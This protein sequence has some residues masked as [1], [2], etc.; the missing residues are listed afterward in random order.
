VSTT[1]WRRGSLRAV[2]DFARPSVNRP[3]VYA[4]LKK[5]AEITDI[6]TAHHCYKGVA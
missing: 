1:H 6:P 2:I 3:G 4:A 5:L